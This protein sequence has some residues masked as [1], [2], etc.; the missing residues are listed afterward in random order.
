MGDIFISII[1]FIVIYLFYLLFVILRKKKLLLFRN[2]IYV[3]Y[4]ESKYKLNISL[5]NLKSLANVIAIA[6][7][8][9]I[10]L[11]FYLIG[12]TDNFLLKMLL[13]FAI[14]IPIQIFI[15]HIIGIFYQKNIRKKENNYV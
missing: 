12:I 6:N 3:R 4:L 1:V 14:L 10:A 2:N 13:A 8:F 15:Y 7:S 11:T 5:L 9:I